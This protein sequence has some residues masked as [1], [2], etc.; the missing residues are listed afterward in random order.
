MALLRRKRK[1]QDEAGFMAEVEPKPA[2]NRLTPVD[3]QQKVFRLSFRGY[4]EHDVDQFLDQ[5]TEDLASLHE[6]NKRLHEELELRGS[7]TGFEDAKRHAEETVRQAREE[8]ARIMADAERRK[9]FLARLFS[10]MAEG[11]VMDA[12]VIG[13]GMLVPEAVTPTRSEDLRALIVDAI[14]DTAERG[15]AV[16]VSHAAAIPLAGAVSGEIVEQYDVD[17]RGVGAVD[18][19]HTVNVLAVQVDLRR[20]GRDGARGHDAN[21]DVVVAGSVGPLGAG[22]GRREDVAEVVRGSRAARDHQELE[23]ARAELRRGVE[24][25]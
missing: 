24:E 14:R 17:G 12:A 2:R 23:E 16:I 4:N 15:N 21:V 25:A 20:P 18:G 1:D 5:V 10:G 11:P 7:P 19:E 3:V 22:A 8:A 13:G 6:E 9:T